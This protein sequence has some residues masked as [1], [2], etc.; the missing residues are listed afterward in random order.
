MGNRHEALAEQFPSICLDC[1]EKG[2]NKRREEGFEVGVKELRV[3]LEW[4]NL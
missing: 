2:T 1:L 3:F 4:L